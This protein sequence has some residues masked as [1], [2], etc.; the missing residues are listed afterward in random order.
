[1]ACDRFV[2]FPKGKRPSKE[3]V[4]KALEDF[5]GAFM[6]SNKWGGGRWTATLV[7]TK[8]WPLRRIYDQSCE[9]LRVMAAAHEEETSE[10]RWIEVFLHRNTI[11]VITRRQDEATMRL[12]DGFAQLAARYWRGQLEDD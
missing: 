1:M 6:V 9:T 8:S 12:A 3:D 11:D 2:R 10:S 5:L 7:G 4:G